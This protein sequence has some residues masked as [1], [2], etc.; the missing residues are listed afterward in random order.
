M[1]YPKQIPYLLDKDFKE[2]ITYREHRIKELEP[3]C[4]CIWEMK[5]KRILDKT[6]SNNI[7][8]DACI[9]I[10]IDFTSKTICFAGF[11]KETEPFALHEKIDYMGV[12][13]R[14][15]V[16]HAAYHTA[17]ENIMDA[18][19]PFTE[20]EE[21]YD[22]REIFLYENSE[23]RINILRGYLLRKMMMI[24]DRTYIIAIEELYEHPSDVRKITQRSG[25]TQRQ[26]YRIFKKNYGVSPRVL[27][28]ILRLHL[29][30]SL[31]TEKDMEFAD[32]AVL[33][34]FYD[35]SHFIREIK[36]YTGISP[37][38]LLEEYMIVL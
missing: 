21:D 24:Y 37:L 26:L 32:I 34:G 25:Y 29:C 27:L 13:L 14:P 30:L 6:I 15:G 33:C 10:V 1:Y 36:R 38:K 28:N 22:L 5:S 11:S 3:C 18:M 8:P 12:R 4:M 2:N 7:L 17:A 20:I 16:F 23:E 35:Q 31:L 19:I 9:D